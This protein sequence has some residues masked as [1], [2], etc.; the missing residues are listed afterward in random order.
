[1]AGTN[2]PVCIGK[3]VGA[4]GVKGGVKI[5]PYTQSDDLFVSG[6]SFTIMHPGMDARE[7]RIT[8]AQGYKNIVRLWMEGVDDREGADALRGSE[9]Y[10]PRSRLPEAD[11]D[12]WYWHDLVG[13]DVYTLTGER[14]GQVDSI[15]ETGANDV[16]VVKGEGRETL[17]PAI[18]PVVLEIDTDAGIIRVDLPEGL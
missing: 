15:I 14:I 17:V 1:M 18:P 11:P 6:E 3:I 4:F 10:I 8:R 7:L 9:I 13:L 16:F 2:L 5:R 12:T